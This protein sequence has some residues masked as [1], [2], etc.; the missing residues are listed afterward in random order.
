MQRTLKGRK[1]RTEK[2]QRK[3]RREGRAGGI[4]KKK[5]KEYL[6]AMERCT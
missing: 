5:K 2:V 3:R 6:Y 4:A 1:H